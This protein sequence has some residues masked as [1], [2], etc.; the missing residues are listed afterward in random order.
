MIRAESA[1]VWDTAVGL[2][3][4]R[5]KEFFREWQQGGSPGRQEAVRRAEAVALSDHLLFMFAFF[6]GLCFAFIQHLH[7]AGFDLKN[8][9]D[10]VCF[11][12]FAFSCIAIIFVSSS[13]PFR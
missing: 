4:Q 12:C 1:F 3:A 8:H 6:F 2:A 11:S 9:F 5:K 10:D 13:S 7:G